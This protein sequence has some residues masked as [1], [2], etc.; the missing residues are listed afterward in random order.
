MYAKF[1]PKKIP[2][3]GCWHKL[4]DQVDQMYKSPGQMAGAVF[5]VLQTTSFQ[6]SQKQPEKQNLSV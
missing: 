2:Q 4:I 5:F 6:R 3:L 1:L